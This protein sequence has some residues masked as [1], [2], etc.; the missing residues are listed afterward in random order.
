MFSFPHFDTDLK[1]WYYLKN[2]YQKLRVEFEKHPLQ[3]VIFG[4]GILCKACKM[5]VRVLMETWGFTLAWR[6]VS[7]L[8]KGLPERLGVGGNYAWCLATVVILF[9]GLG[10]TKKWE[11][12][13][14]FYS[15]I[16]IFFKNRASSLLTSNKILHSCKKLEKTYDQFLK[17][18]TEQA[19][20]HSWSCST[21][22]LCTFLM[23]PFMCN[24]AYT[25][26]F[27]RKPILRSCI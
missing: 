25:I 3:T 2:Y 21:F 27:F 22:L 11:A 1:Y 16:R 7:S 4:V 23:V 14:R 13:G 6:Q 24:K 18:K 12:G 9:M 10:G 8:Q 26:F 17:K 20:G 19:D 5:F 15:Q